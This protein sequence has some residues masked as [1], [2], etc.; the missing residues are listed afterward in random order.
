LPVHPWLL[1]LL[2]PLTILAQ[3]GLEIAPRQSARGLVF[4][5]L[6]ASLLWLTWRW[7]TREW[8]LSGLLTSAALLVFQAYGRFYAGSGHSLLQTLPILEPLVGN[9]LLLLPLALATLAFI[10]LAVVRLRRYTTGMTHLLNAAGLALCLVSLGTI[11]LFEWRL[12]QPPGGSVGLPDQADLADSDDAAPDIYYIVL[13]GYG[14]SDVLTEFYQHDNGPFIDKLERDGFTVI[15]SARS[16]Y[17]QTGLSLASTLNLD[18]LQSFVDLEDPADSGQVRLSVQRWLRHN[19]LADE[20][21]QLG[22]QLVT[23]ENGYRPTELAGAE[24]HGP[25]SAETNLLERLLIENSGLTLL[26]PISW[27]PGAIRHPGYD[28]H[29]TRIDY[30]F[31]SLQA[32]L[33]GSQGP[34]FVFVHL[35][36]PHPPFVFNDSG[37]PILPPYPYVLLDGSAYP[38]DSAHYVSLY[39]AQLEYVNQR[40]AEMLDAMVGRQDR[41]ALIILQ[42]DHGPGSELDW[43]SLEATEPRERFGILLAVR[44]PDGNAPADIKFCSPVNL[45]RWVLTSLFG[46]D[47][48]ALP[49]RSY[50]STWDEP[51]IFQQV[52]DDQLAPAGLQ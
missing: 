10:F 6:L 52:D 23:F 50:Y 45:F 31:S 3:N 43:S 17:M 35:L 8:R 48:P 21:E 46:A 19:R 41:Q 7:W 24:M 2:T 37:E 1:A 51:H 14:R 13:D 20:L 15:E 30:V 28:L 12:A 42:G 27:M 16:N 34:R 44:P 47:L 32:G 36:V 39:R 9:H 4:E 22:Y 33:P 26:Q 25:A 5:L 18:Y 29:R 38:G 49:D 40:L 11:G